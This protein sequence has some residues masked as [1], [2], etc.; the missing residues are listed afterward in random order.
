MREAGPAALNVPVVLF[1]ASHC[2][3]CTIIKEEFL[4]PMLLSGDY[5]DKVLIRKL[6][7]DGGRTL[8]S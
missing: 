8:T 5:V 1:S 4:K 2:G 7:I 3:Y 6:V